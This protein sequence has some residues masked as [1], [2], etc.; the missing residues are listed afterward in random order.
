MLLCCT[1]Q[2][3]SSLKLLGICPYKVLCI[4]LVNQCQ[5][6]KIGFLRFRHCFNTLGDTVVGS[7]HLQC[8]FY[9]G[10]TCTSNWLYFTSDG[11]TDCFGSIFKVF[12]DVVVPCPNIIGQFHIAQ[13]HLGSIVIG[14]T[15]TSQHGSK[16]RTVLH[17]SLDVD[18][19]FF[20]QPLYPCIRFLSLLS[21]TT[22]KTS[23][24][25]LP[26][27]CLSNDR[28]HAQGKSIKS[29]DNCV[30]IVSKCIKIDCTHI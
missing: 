21:K 23:S 19:K 7:S 29:V 9:N 10:E 24:N 22:T 12:V 20:I 2:T 17:E 8:C 1:H 3:F 6:T 4:C 13:C 26:L 18:T 28:F 16:D 11:R 27:D 30:D 5:I 14:Y 15:E 25:T